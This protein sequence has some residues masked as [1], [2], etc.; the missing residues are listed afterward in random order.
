LLTVLAAG[1]SA[2]WYRHTYNMWPGQDASTR[3]H[4]CG[5]D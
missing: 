4:W 1:G 2:I 3:V 5:R